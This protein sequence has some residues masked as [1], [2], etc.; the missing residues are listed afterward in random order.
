MASTLKVKLFSATTASVVAIGILGLNAYF[1]SGILANKLVQTHLV[2]VGL[3][4]HTLAD[5]MHDALRADVFSALYA[6][7][8]SPE[9]KQQIAIATREHAAAFKNFISMN[10]ELAL[11]AELKTALAHVEESL[12]TYVSSAEDL[13]ATAFENERRA[14]V[15]LVDFEKQF[16]VLEVALDAEGDKFEAYAKTESDSAK[17]F[18]AQAKELSQLGLLLGLL[19][20]AFTVWVMRRDV[21]APLTAMTGAMHR[22]ANGNVDAI[23]AAHEIR[24]QVLDFHRINHDFLGQQRHYFQ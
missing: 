5:M 17:A 12:Q 18:A 19:I 11:P 14:E 4:N 6:A 9:R 13:V 16:S 7:T 24:A 20:S 2:A 1:C 22:L 3:R 15:Q 10:K 21:L 8:K 23:L